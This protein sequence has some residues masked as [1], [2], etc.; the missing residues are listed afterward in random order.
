MRLEFTASTA[1]QEVLARLGRTEDLNFSPSGRRLAL[2]EFAS[3]RLVILG[4]EIVAS[5]AG[6]KVALTDCM[7][8]ASSGLC[9]PHGVSFLDEE[10]LVVGNRAGGVSLLKVPAGGTVNGTLVVP[11]LKPC[12]ATSGC[13]PPVRSS[14]SRI[15]RN[16][17]ALLVCNNYAHHVSRHV[18][19]V[20]AIRWSSRA[21]RSC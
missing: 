2:A 5:Q 6:A 9:E 21:T 12:A 8:L 1:V 15:D 11:A 3:D 7:K 20:V 10:T 19:N 14:V 16:L 4:V 13:I 17:Y 18:L